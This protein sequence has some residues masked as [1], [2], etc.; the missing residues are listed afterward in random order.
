MGSWMHCLLKRHQ[1]F[2][3]SQTRSTRRTRK[4]HHCTIGY[5]WIVSKH[6]NGL[7]ASFLRPAFVASPR[8][9][10]QCRWSQVWN[11]RSECIWQCLTDFDHGIDEDTLV[12]TQLVLSLFDQAD[13]QLK[14]IR[15]RQANHLA[16]QVI[17]S[18][19]WQRYWWRPD[20]ASQLSV[21]VVVV[22]CLK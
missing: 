14:L 12:W 1:I 6:R 7:G 3:F 11:P 16:I 15:R 19:V 5:C 10:S 9:I 4:W 18:S 8:T 22:Y 13:G 20:A 2:S 17:T 21:V